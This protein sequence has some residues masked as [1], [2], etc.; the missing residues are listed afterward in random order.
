MDVQGEY[1]S[2]VENAKGYFL[3]KDTTD[4]FYGHPAG[5]WDDAKDP[6]L[7]PLHGS[8]LSGL[9]PAIDESCVRFGEVLRS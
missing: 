3:E 4:W 6:R 2:R 5:A 9:P 8:D 1:P 7:S